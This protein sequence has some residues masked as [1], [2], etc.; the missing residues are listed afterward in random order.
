MVFP[1]EVVSNVTDAR[2]SIEM[3]NDK[4]KLLKGSKKDAVNVTAY[5]KYFDF[6]EK[7]GLRE[8]FSVITV[9]DRLVL[10]ATIIRPLIIN[11]NNNKAVIF[12]HGLTNN[13]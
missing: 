2:V 9:H 6:L 8:E 12:C 11:K 7:L 5:Q 4:I 3:I 10:Y 13:R 1:S